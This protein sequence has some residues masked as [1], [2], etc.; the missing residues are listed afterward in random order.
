MT[1]N[2]PVRRL[3]DWSPKRLRA[4]AGEHGTPLYVLDPDRGRE[5]AARL[6]E[7]FPEADVSYALKANTKIGRAHV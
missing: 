6:R 3:S 5:N 4:L 7:A 2:P 1:E